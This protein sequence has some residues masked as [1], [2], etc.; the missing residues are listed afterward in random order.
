MFA[1]FQVDHPTDDDDDP[2]ASRQGGKKKEDTFGNRVSTNQG[3]RDVFFSVLVFLVKVGNRLFAS[4]LCV[5]RSID[6]HSVLGPGG[7]P[8]SFTVNLSLLSL[9]VSLSF[10]V[11]YSAN[12]T[13]LK[14]GLPAS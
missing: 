5:Y 10:S 13:Y 11:C 9:S 7:L 3:G 2:P 1:C 6:H 4:S 12:L 14:G 8:V